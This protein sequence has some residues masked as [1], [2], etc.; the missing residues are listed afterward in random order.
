MPPLLQPRR[1]HLPPPALD[2][3]RAQRRVQQRPAHHGAAPPGLDDH[4]RFLL[5]HGDLNS[6]GAL[7]REK[8]TL[9]TRI[10]FGPGVCQEGARTLHGNRPLICSGELVGY[11]WTQETQEVSRVR[12]S[13]PEGRGHII[14]PSESQGLHL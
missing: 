14:L 10:H 5:R 6:L 4:C 3:E 8:G 12:L 11:S 9:R 7:L 13:L 2:D 1:L